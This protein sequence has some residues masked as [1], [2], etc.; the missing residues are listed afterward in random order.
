VLRLGIDLGGTK[1]EAALF[2]PIGEVVWRKR[3]P[4]PQHHYAD[5]VHAIAGLIQEARHA[6][7]AAEV[8]I[9]IGIPGSLSPA[10]GHV[11]NANSTWLNGRPL[12]A[13]LETAVGQTV[14]VANDANCLAISEATD[15]AARDADNSFSIILGTGVGGGLV[16]HKQ[17]V[18]G[19]NGIAG[20]WGHTPLPWQK[21][22]EQHHRS[23]CWCGRQ[24]CIET[25]LSGPALVKEF[26]QASHL[27]VANVEMLLEQRTA[28]NPVAKAVMDNF[29]DRL[30]RALAMVMNV[31]DP[32][33][34]VVA[35]GLSNIH[36]IYTE[37]PKRWQ[38]WIF[39]DRP[40]R[41]Q[42]LPAMYGDASGVRGAAWLPSQ[43]VNLG[44]RHQA[45]RQTDSQDDT[46]D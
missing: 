39:S 18:I 23:P 22:D 30:A 25:F 8:S 4:S 19:T 41:T 43:G 11:R 45:E 35:G 36:E 40:A 37:I 2:S 5:T 33:V 3:I 1:I 27:S 13:D 12:R 20:E 16:L 26:N 17:L 15:G 34:I 42:L 21:D 38:P 44:V 28:G 31:V 14:S 9:G 10:D 24:G 7:T 6:H 29:F 46:G 32:D